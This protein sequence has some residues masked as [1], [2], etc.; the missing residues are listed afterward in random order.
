M[1]LL[2]SIDEDDLDKDNASSDCDKTSATVQDIGKG[3]LAE[4]DE[5]R[6]CSKA[7]VKVLTRK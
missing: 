3:I 6:A 1:V 5:I 2:P 7:G 4:K